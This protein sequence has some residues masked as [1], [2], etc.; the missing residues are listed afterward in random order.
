MLGVF[1]LVIRELAKDPDTPL[2]GESV[3]DLLAE[4]LPTVDASELFETLVNWGRSGQLFD[5]DARSD[6]L[7][8]YSGREEDADD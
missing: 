5:F 7:A 8:L 4:R 3:R 1:G 2:T 6:T